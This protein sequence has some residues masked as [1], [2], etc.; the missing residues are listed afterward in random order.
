MRKWTTNHDIVFCKELLVSRLFETR[1][2]SSERG[3]VWEAI[4]KRLEVDYPCFQVDQHS[5]RDR[6]KKMLLQFWKQDRKKWNASGISPEQTELDVLLEK[7][8]AQEE[9]SETPELPSLTVYP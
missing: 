7:I 2:K 6:L 5:V 4:A 3:Q 8:N 1:K 9:A